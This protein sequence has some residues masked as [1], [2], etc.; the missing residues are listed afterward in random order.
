MMAIDHPILGPV[1]WLAAELQPQKIWKHFY[2][3]EEAWQELVDADPVQLRGEVERRIG[4][5]RGSGGVLPAAWRKAEPLLAEHHDALYGPAYM[6]ELCSPEACHSAGCDQQRRRRVLTPNSVFVVV[7]AAG[8]LSHVLTA[9]R[10]HPRTRFV[11][12]KEGRRKHALWYFEK[13]CGTWSRERDEHMSEMAKPRTMQELW[14]WAVRAGETERIEDVRA[15]VRALPASLVEQLVNALDWSAAEDALA[16]SLRSDDLCEFEKALLDAEDLL[17]VATVLGRVEL[18]EQFLTR[19]EPVVAW[20]P[21]DWTSVAS[22]AAKR[23]ES[24][25]APAEAP[26]VQ[27]W[28]SVRSAVMGDALRAAAPTRRN[29]ASLVDELLPAGAPIKWLAELVDG[30]GHAGSAI[31]TW[32][33]GVLAR[34]SVQQLAVQMGAQAGGGVWEL[35]GLGGPPNGNVRVFVSDE[36]HKDGFDVTENWCERADSWHLER[37][38]QEVVVVFVVSDGPMPAGSL[39]QLVAAAKSGSPLRIAATVVSRPT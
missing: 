1:M 37:P 24:S 5:R 35:R 2:A 12:D 19:L 9:F 31:T 10:P 21:G 23:L 17:I 28:Q 14:H 18:A 8:A 36:E 4:V 11:F 29:V 3:T 20:T 15:F 38:G 30:V 16:S 39:E 13:E 26:T 34:V 33:K 32:L 25:E 22:L 27:F 6:R 7:N